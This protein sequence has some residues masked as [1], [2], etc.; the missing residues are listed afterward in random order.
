MKN[1]KKVKKMEKME[2]EVGVVQIIE[3]DIERTEGSEM[4]E[5]IK[6]NVLSEYFDKFILPS[7]LRT[8]IKKIESIR[9]D[10]EED[11][12]EDEE[13]D[14]DKEEDEEEEIKSIYILQ[15]VNSS[16]NYAE[17]DFITLSRDLSEKNL[18]YRLAALCYHKR[19]NNKY[20]IY[21]YYV[22]YV[23]KAKR[24]LRTL[25]KIASMDSV[26]C[27]YLYSFTYKNAFKSFFNAILQKL[28]I[29]PF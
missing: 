20:D 27:S 16:K 8:A 23:E 14:E 22:C 10:F 5:R 29:P 24:T 25:Y 3:I 6:N 17:C 19:K 28:S 18:N 2:D 4:E 9:N 13:E 21:V 11:D 15:E 26:T 7:E 12:E 1:E